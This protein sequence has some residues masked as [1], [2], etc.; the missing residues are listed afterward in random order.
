MND[1]DSFVF[2]L[3]PSGGDSTPTDKTIYG[4]PGNRQVGDQSGINA[5]RTQG[6]SALDVKKNNVNPQFTTD[7]KEVV[8]VQNKDWHGQTYNDY[9]AA[10]MAGNYAFYGQNMGK[11]NPAGNLNNM[12]FNRTLNMSR[13]TD[14]FNNRLRHRAD[15]RGIGQ[16]NFVSGAGVSARTGSNGQWVNRDIETEEIR[17]MERNRQL[18]ALQRGRQTGRA[19]DVQDHKLELQKNIDQNKIELTQ[20]LGTSE[21]ELNRFM[22]E[23]IFNSQYTKSWDTFWTNAVTEFAQTL[24]YEIRE[25]CARYL[26]S[27]KDTFAKLLGQ[28]WDGVITPGTFEKLAGNWVDDAVRASGGNSTQGALMKYIYKTSGLSKMMFNFTRNN[29]AD[30]VNLP[31]GK[32]QSYF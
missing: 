4:D 9:A 6:A 22:Q 29:F 16:E 25:W 1:E 19:E 12:S 30:T 31:F 13:L 18:D 15:P 7:D 27:Q 3:D 11:N 24:P 26:I 8:R 21:V 10:A 32:H 2:A 23:N 5:P 20:Q 17:Q 28:F 14:A